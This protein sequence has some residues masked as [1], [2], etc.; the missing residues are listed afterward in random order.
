MPCKK[1]KCECTDFNKRFCK[2][3]TPVKG[4]E[5]IGELQWFQGLW[6]DRP[7]VCWITGVNLQFNVAVFF[8]VLP[9]GAYPKFA[10]L[11]KNLIFVHPSLHHDW[12]SLGK[13]ELLKRDSRWQKVFDLYEEL[14]IEYY[15]K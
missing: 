10:R 13:S 15:R 7:H 11:E 1:S 12:H 3:Y 14:K 5:K 8:H 9:K 4:P 2:S 6:I